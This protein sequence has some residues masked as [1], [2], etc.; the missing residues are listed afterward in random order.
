MSTG[1]G[2]GIAPFGL[3]DYGSIT[4]DGQPLVT[5]GVG[6]VYKV[7]SHRREGGA[8]LGGKNSVR[9][10]YNGNLKLNVINHV[11]V[12]GNVPISLRTLIFE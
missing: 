1:G 11:D 3:D 5:G 12:S 8:I 2:Y 4:E 9:E 7:I 10:S 6:V